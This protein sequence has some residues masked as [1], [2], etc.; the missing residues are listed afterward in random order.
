MEFNAI[1][2]MGVI[3]KRYRTLPGAEKGRHFVRKL[4]AGDEA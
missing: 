2:A 1:H 3:L 4:V